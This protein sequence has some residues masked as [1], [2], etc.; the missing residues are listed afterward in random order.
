[1]LSEVEGMGWISGNGG[2]ETSS[3]PAASMG[4]MSAAPPFK[5]LLLED[6]GCNW[7]MPSFPDPNS[8][9]MNPALESSSS[10]SPLFFGL[11]SH[12]PFLDHHFLTRGTGI[13][14][15]GFCD[16]STQT[17]PL[18]APDF[19][20]HGGSLG[21]NNR[22]SKLLKPLDR[23][24]TSMGAQPTLFQ[25]RAA[26]AAVRRNN[27]AAA[28]ITTADDKKTAAETNG[29]EVEYWNDSDD[30]LV[31]KE[32]E[33][34]EEE[35]AQNN[36]NGGGGMST[37]VTGG[38]DQ[39]GKKK[40]K[41]LPAKNLMAER[42]RR[43]KLNDRLYTLRSVVPKISKMNRASIL[44]D[45]IEYLK[46][47]LQRINDLQNELDS[48]PSSS[49]S[50][51]ATSFYPVTPTAAAASSLTSCHIKEEISPTPHPPRACLTLLN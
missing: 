10:S 34:E 14:S 7:Y 28:N 29:D 23:S 16:F 15:G 32:I 12:N 40:K 43:K 22:P 20:L 46:E 9:F 50:A 5:S 41:G 11:G 3:Q 35:D 1:M 30:A 2:L 4:S 45:A 26:A 21:F 31:Q 13:S 44:A 33:A 48:A 6:V 18:G 49:S 19:N 47:L 38:G 8:L 17:P 37:T 42:R 27:L 36:H 25:K 24:G 51:V 39:R